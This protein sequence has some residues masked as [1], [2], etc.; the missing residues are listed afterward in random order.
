MRKMAIPKCLQLFAPLLCKVVNPSLLQRIL[1][2]KLT[3]GPFQTLSVR[4]GTIVSFG[5]N[6]PCIIQPIGELLRRAKR[7]LISIMF[8]V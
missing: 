1:V 5:T 2:P 7:C 6:I 8:T 3:L 4:N